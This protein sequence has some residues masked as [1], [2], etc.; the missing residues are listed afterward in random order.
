MRYLNSWMLLPCAGVFLLL[1]ACGGLET[2]KEELAPALTSADVQ[3]FTFEPEVN[4]KEVTLK[5]GIEVDVD[6]LDQELLW[7]FMW[8]V[9]EGTTDREVNKLTVGKGF[10]RGDYKFI[11]SDFP[12][13]KNIV[14]CAF[15]DFK[16]SPNA[17]VEQILGVEFEFD[18]K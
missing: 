15:V 5:A 10:F 17:E 1:S 4:E 3:V 2:S 18:A 12:S 8:F 6:K 11:K 13:D 14:F 7:G 9:D 16:A